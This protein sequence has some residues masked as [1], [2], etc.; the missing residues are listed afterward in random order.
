MGRTLG[1][2]RAPTAPHCRAR[3]RY[4]SGRAARH[5]DGD[6]LHRTDACDCRS[7]VRRHDLSTSSIKKKYTIGCILEED[8]GA[9]LRSPLNV[10]DGVVGAGNYWEKIQDSM[11]MAE[12]NHPEART[13]VL[14]RRL[15]EKQ[16]R[17]VMR[18]SKQKTV[19]VS[20]QK[21]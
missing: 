13:L 10:F 1:R 3:G 16:R 21:V 19:S 7:S 5:G 20:A 8:L 4:R 11:E 15:P 18:A 17:R 12:S 9:E 6:H 2:Y 14:R